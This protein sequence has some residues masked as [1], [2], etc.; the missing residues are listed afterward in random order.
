MTDVRRDP[1]S[2]DA[3]LSWDA[4]VVVSTPLPQ[5]APVDPPDHQR[6]FVDAV[7]SETGLTP[8]IPASLRGSNLTHTASTAVR[9]VGYR[10]AFHALRS[11]KYALKT[12][13][14]APVGVFRGAWRICSW[15]FDWEADS[16]RQHTITRNNTAEYLQLAKLR[17]KRVGGRMPFAV[18][19]AVLLA[20]AV[21]LLLYVAPP[22]WKWAALAVVMPI[23]AVV[24]RPADKP[25]TDRVSNSERFIKLTAEMTRRALVAC[26]AGIKDPAH[27][28][29]PRDIYRDPPGWT[30]IVNLPD[31]VIASDVIDKRERLAGGFRLP[32]SQVWPAGVEGEHPGLLRIWVADRPVSSMKQP[33]WPLLRGGE[34]DYFKSFPYG[35]DERMNP[36]MWTLDQKN[37]LFAGIPGSGK[38]LAV[39]VVLLG[40]VLDPLVVPVVFELKGIG[41]FDDFETL[42]PKGL[43]GSGADEDTKRRAMGALEWLLHECETRATLI[44]RYAAAGLNKTNNV[45]RAM[46]ERDPRLRPIVAVFD[47][48]QELL[49][50]REIG[51]AAVGM[52]TSII[53]RGRALGIHLILA[54]QRIDKESI[55]R[56]ISSNVAMRV[57]MAATSHVEVDLV[58]GTGAYSRGARPT[59]FETATDDD[60]KD[61]G[62]GWRVGLGP[63]APMRAAY[64]DNEWTR[65]IVRRVIAQRTSLGMMPSDEEVDLTFRDPLA[66]VYSVFRAG[67]AWVSWEAI[68]E[69]LAEQQ[70]QVYAD[71]TKETVSA[72]IR[73]LD[74][75]S[76]DGRVPGGGVLKGAK[77][78]AIEAAM[79]R[80]QIE[81]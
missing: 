35:F 10:T 71:V 23:L 74:V 55:P 45:N 28:T 48:V 79:K 61:S 78:A 69:R 26:G 80:R 31:G 14:W 67:E 17:D 24:G 15:A 37:S 9:R 70:P 42:C 32:K 11:P 27:I 29:F 2:L 60:P 47:E 33:A 41:D 49:T 34:V 4:E 53:K 46:A 3:A 65:A 8:L 72:Q 50:D 22:W 57:C 12:T 62:W 43:Y 75:K 20:A 51:K 59:E 40:A 30:A 39:R 25:I 63:M 44:K 6:V 73:A 64:V 38:S 77:R 5:G 19:G 66:D 56:G 81:D 1:D 58:L 21:L 76:E 68:A 18:A 13:L 52:T 7:V 16:L 54:T 36:T